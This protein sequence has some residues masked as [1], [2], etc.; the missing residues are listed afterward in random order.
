MGTKV[1]LFIL[2][3]ILLLSSAGAVPAC[4]VPP[5]SSLLSL[6]PHGAVQRADSRQF[7]VT[8]PHFPNLI[9]H[10][11]LRWGHKMARVSAVALCCY[12]VLLP[13]MAFF[14][15]LWW[16]KAIRIVQWI[17]A[18]VYSFALSVSSL[19]P[20]CRQFFLTLLPIIY[21]FSYNLGLLLLPLG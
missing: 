2:Y 17:W 10:P 9:F 7:S 19:F 1:P 16:H 18:V 6:G 12:G 4:A 21:F 3:L 20:I 8:G 13:F 15:F 5:I 11:E 14:I